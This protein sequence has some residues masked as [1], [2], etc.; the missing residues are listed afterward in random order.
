[1][2][3]VPILEIDSLSVAFHTLEGKMNAVRNVSF[4]ID[5]GESVGI[6]GESGSGKSVTA[7]S[8]MGLIP[9]PPGQI[10]SGRILFHGENLFEKKIE[11]INHIR[12]NRISMIF[13]EPMTSLNPIHTCGKQIMEAILIH[14]DKS[15]Q[16]AYDRA[17][18]LMEVVGIPNATKR[19]AEYPHQLSGGMRQR[20]MIA[21]ALA[22]DPEILIAD[23]PTT[24]LDVTIQAQVLDLLQDLKKQFNSSIIMITHDIGVIAQVCQRII[25]MYNGQIVEA[26]LYKDLY[27]KQFHPYSQ[28]LLQSMPKMTRGEKLSSIKGQVPNPYEKL[29]GCGFAPR[30]DYCEDICTQIEPELQEVQPGRFARCHFWDRVGGDANDKQ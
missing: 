6:V 17:L 21:M 27:L 28:G 10:E 2:D 25:V 26:S 19:M 30:C 12:G 22:C 14:T 15:K 1:M 5:A 8:I 7:L 24:A 18:H 9:T 3:E 16:E 20:V 29:E 4:S 13:Q 23:E 11:E